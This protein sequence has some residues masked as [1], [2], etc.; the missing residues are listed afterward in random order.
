MEK[1]ER[2]KGELSL[3]QMILAHKKIVENAKSLYED[4]TLL[5]KNKKFPRAYF[6]MCIANEELGK[7]IIVLSSII[8]LILED[9]DWHQFWKLLRNHKDKTSMIEYAE[10]IFVSSEDNFMPPQIISK[11]IPTFEELKMASLYS[12]MFQENFF[13]PNEIIPEQLASSYLKLT[14]NRI[15]F[16]SSVA[17]SDDT[18]KSIKRDDI[19][20]YREKLHKMLQEYRDKC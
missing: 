7:S 15:K 11:L 4:A 10:N 19:L 5:Y 3:E 6:L 16:F 20:R 9:V 2:Y 1:L 17:L 8:D 18:I 12:D 13:Q 14:G